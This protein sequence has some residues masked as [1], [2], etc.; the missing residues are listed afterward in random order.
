MRLA[1][2]FFAQHGAK[3]R[4]AF[5]HAFGMTCNAGHKKLF[6]GL[7]HIEQVLLDNGYIKEHENVY[8]SRRLT[9]LD[10][11]Q[12]GE[13]SVVYGEKNPQGRQEFSI[14]CCGEYVG[15]GEL[16]YLPLGEMCY[17]RWIYT[18]EKLQGKGC[19][20]AALNRI[21]SD[22][23]SAGIH[24]IDTDTA[25]GNPIAQ[26]LYTKTGFAD[27]G[28]TRSYLHSDNMKMGEA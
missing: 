17:L 13:I 14:H 7:P 10:I 23:Y 20:S 5:Y 26:R 25:D 11:Q 2:E 24:R 16:A 9:E 27:M 18:E 21:F 3:K 28:R 12:P 6:C 4:Y 15:A 19:A 22:L 8:Y 1:E